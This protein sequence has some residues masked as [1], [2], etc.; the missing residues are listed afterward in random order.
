LPEP[1]PPPEAP[2]ENV[3]GYDR[4]VQGCFEGQ[5]YFI[6]PN[7]QRLPRNYDNL[8]ASSVLYACE[9]DIPTR[10]WEQGFPGLPE[11][12]EWFAIRYSGAFHIATTGKYVFRLSSDDGARLTIDGRVV[13]DND[14][15]H[16]PQDKHDEIKLTAGDHTMVLEYFQ[17]PRYHINLQL[18]A[19]PAGG[20]EGIFSVRPH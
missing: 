12:F 1:I 19:T 3:F 18:F 13:I 4:P 17:G 10:A 7:S 6:E 8:E 2:P 16:P 5:V 9:W 11:R 20:T 14:G 15:V